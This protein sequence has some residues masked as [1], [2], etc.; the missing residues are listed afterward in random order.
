MLFNR[1]AIVGLGLIG[2]SFA[3]AARRAGIARTITGCGTSESIEYALAH[4]VIDEVETAFYD[5]TESDADLVYLATPVRAIIDFLR[6]RA[7][8]IKPGAIITDAGSTKR[9]ICLAARES[10]TRDS[11]AEKIFF[12]GGHPM[13]GSHRTGIE[14]ASADIFQNAPYAVVPDGVGDSSD[15]NYTASVS[16]LIDTVRAIG[17]RPILVNAARHDSTVAWVS[18]MPQLLSTALAVAVARKAES[19]ELAGTGF[20]DM[21]R[22][23]ASSWSVWEDVCRTNADEISAAL[24]EVILEIEAIRHGLAEGRFSTLAQAFEEANEFSRDPARRA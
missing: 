22:L 11:L 5:G 7:R 10:L 9:E 24:G 1:I 8:Q 15:R 21:T 4:K 19:C 18:H 17:S 12:I 13:A 3:L 23:A 2:G 16:A 20:A 14:S 6:T